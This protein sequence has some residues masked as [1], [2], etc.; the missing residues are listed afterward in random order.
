MMEV[1]DEGQ[2]TGAEFGSLE[3]VSPEQIEAGELACINLR[4]I[5][6]SAGLARGGTLTIWTDS[7][8]DWAKPQVEDPTADG[9]L[10]LVPPIGCAAS[11][12]TPDHKSFVITLMSGKL[13]EGDSIDIILGDRSGGG[14]GLRAQTFYEPRRNFLCEVNPSGSGP[15]TWTPMGAETRSDSFKAEQVGQQDTNFVTQ[16]SATGSAT[17]AVLRISGGDA[18]E[19]SAIAPS[20]IELGS[21]FALQLKASDIWG[22]PAEKY[23]GTVEIKAP[24]LVVPGGNSLEFSEEDGGVCRIEGA[25]FTEEGATRIDIEDA[26]NGLVASSNQIRISQELPALKLFWGDPH[27]GQIG[28]ASKIGDYFAYARDVSALDFA[29]YQR[30]DSAHSTDEYEV[31]QVEEKAYHEP[32]RFVPLP[33]YEWS[34]AVEIGGHHNVYFGRFDRPMKRWRGADK[35]GRPDESDLPHVKDL[36]NYYRGTDTVITP[37]VGGTHANL[38]WHDPTLE[39]AIEVTSTHGSFEWILR[40]SI[41]KGYEMGF[42]GG[43]DCHTGRAGDDRPGFQERRYSKGGLTG[44]Y[45]E[46]LTLKSILE[47]MKAKRLYATTGARIR[48]AVTVDGHFI[49]EKYSCGNK[50]EIKVNVEGTAPLERIEVYRGLNL[51]HTEVISGPPAGNK[52]RVLWDG[53]SR[54]SSYSGIRWDGSVDVADGEIGDV[55]PIRFDSPRSNYQRVSSS[56]LALNGWA[57]GYPSGLVFDVSKSTDSEISFAMNSSLIVGP[58]FAA[59]GEK[60]ALRRMAHATGDSVRVNGTLAQ[61]QNG[62]MRVNLGHSNRN[63]TLELAPE[64]VSDRSEFTVID[65]D[66]QPGVNPYWVKVVQQDMEMAWISPVFADLLG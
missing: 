36:H 28:D 11:I 18:S 13:S 55:S 30:N 4:Y 43:N 27:S 49:G 20:D 41:G 2:I 40:E 62:P 12:H 32:G 15:D 46:Q 52:I 34:G 54:W 7:D 26:E 14:G 45:A 5:A 29:G 48:A 19:L 24:G 1:S 10:N 38:E 65:A 25:V 53:A 56:K 22:N 3:L 60:Q 58:T 51:I 17:P 31:Q 44:I 23:R 9:Y 42:V 59:H 64:A 16:G 21:G 61:L 8:S 50:C 47:A 66:V 63:V 35:L 57:C 37:H 33:G 39:P 6:G